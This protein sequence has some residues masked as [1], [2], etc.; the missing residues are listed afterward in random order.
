MAINRDFIHYP[1]QTLTK[2]ATTINNKSS[3]TEFYKPAIDYL[4]KYSLKNSKY[5]LEST[6]KY[7]TKANEIIHEFNNIPS[8]I[9]AD[10]TSY[11]FFVSIR[12]L[13]R[14][15]L[16]NWYSSYKLN[17]E[18][19]ILLQNS[20]LLLQNLVDIVQDIKR[21][22]LWLSDK[23]LISTVAKCMKNIDQLI[24][25]DKDKHNF[26]QFSHLFDILITYYQYLPS[27]SQD[28][29]I[30]N[31]L[32]RATIDCLVSLN[33]EHL[34]RKLRPSTKSLSIEEH[35]FLIQCPRFFTLYHDIKEI[36]FFRL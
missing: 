24:Y 34:F 12:N 14:N 6:K 32:F 8:S 19:A 15:I 10:L 35:Y 20:I 11:E 18:E 25:F 7:L 28:K 21:L 2:Q 26:R 9:L 17:Q 29:N 23:S 4:V 36:S 13:I 3:Y 31:Q 5:K 30:F 1:I 16:F 27:K 22:S 33:F